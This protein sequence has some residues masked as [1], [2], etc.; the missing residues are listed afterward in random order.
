VHVLSLFLMILVSSQRKQNRS[1]ADAR[2]FTIAYG[3]RSNFAAHAD[4][5]KESPASPAV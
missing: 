3:R 4:G 5:R 2:R 1:P